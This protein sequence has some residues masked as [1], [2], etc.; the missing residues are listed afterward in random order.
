MMFINQ[1]CSISTEQQMLTELEDTNRLVLLVEENG[2]VQRIKNN[3]HWGSLKN[4]RTANVW[5]L[6]NG[7]QEKDK[8]Q[9]E[10]DL[11]EEYKSRC[12]SLILE[13]LKKERL[14]GENPSNTTMEQIRIK[15]RRIGGSLSRSQGFIDVLLERPTECVS[16]KVGTEVEDGA[17]RIDLEQ[18]KLNSFTRSLVNLVNRKIRVD[19]VFQRRFQDR[20]QELRALVECKIIQCGKM[21]L[22]NKVENFSTSIKRLEP[23]VH[24]LFVNSFSE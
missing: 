5:I 11:S 21:E 16:N 8:P 18:Q 6:N 10:E 22:E 4:I 20:Q 9:N 12:I 17:T 19:Q 24:K 2:N 14:D 23:V 1:N 7:Y 3:E 15:L 13:Y